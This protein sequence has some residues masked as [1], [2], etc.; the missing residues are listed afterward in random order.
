MNAGIPVWNA[1]KPLYPATYVE[2]ID[3]PLIAPY[4]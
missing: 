3:V 4:N 1:A 2:F